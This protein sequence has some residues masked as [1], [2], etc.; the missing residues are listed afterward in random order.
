MEVTG[1]P[2]SEKKSFL[3]RMWEAQYGKQYGITAIIS[4]A[5]GILLGLC[6]YQLL[7]LQDHPDWNQHTGLALT[8]GLT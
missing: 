4:G 6:A 3:S 5:S 8:L 2:M 1:E 7:F